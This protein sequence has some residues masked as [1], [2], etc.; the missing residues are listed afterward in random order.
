M[1]IVR[2]LVLGLMLMLSF[3]T[4]RFISSMFV[5]FSPTWSRG[6]GLPSLFWAA[7]AT[8]VSMAPVAVVLLVARRWKSHKE[9]AGRLNGGSSASAVEAPERTGELT[10]QDVQ[11]A[12]PGPA[13]ISEMAWRPWMTLGVA[14]SLLLVVAFLAIQT[15]NRTG[16]HDQRV[17]DWKR[18][19]NLY[20]RSEVS[21]RARLRKAI[22]EA[23]A[24]SR[25][26]D[27]T[28]S[29][30]SN[31]EFNMSAQV[32]A[33]QA[34]EPPNDPS[35]GIEFLELRNIDTAG[36]SSFSGA[37]RTRVTIPGEII[38]FLGE[39]SN[40]PAGGVALEVEILD[41]NRVEL[42]TSRIEL[43]EE[44]FKDV[45]L[46]WT[47]PAFDR[48]RYDKVESGE[49]ILDIPFEWTISASFS[50][51]DAHYTRIRL[52]PTRLGWR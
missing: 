39:L 41:A 15:V 24:A 31:N 9:P 46:F 47:H 43:T 49:T 2:V 8:L 3:P 17:E 48:T 29:H 16:T 35:S 25:S 38:V 21:S 11:S 13:V 6:G 45:D 7:V 30:F 52:V 1:K 5:S 10:A 28:D 40:I 44:N 42:A 26:L 22:E 51:G 27:A 19:P 50:A 4:A 14:L 37:W 23:R 36:N 32:R 18:V 20:Y 33:T 12:H 34:I